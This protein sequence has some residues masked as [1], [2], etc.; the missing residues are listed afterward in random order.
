[1]GEKLPLGKKM[2][3]KGKP[4]FLCDTVEAM[5]QQQ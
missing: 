5:R 4:P 3:T 1:M 2:K